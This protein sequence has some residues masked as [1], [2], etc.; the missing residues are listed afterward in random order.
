MPLIALCL[1]S[2][3]PAYQMPQLPFGNCVVL[4]MTKNVQQFP[5]VP[6]GAVPLPVLFFCCQ[7]IGWTQ[8]HLSSEKRPWPDG[9][10][11]CPDTFTK[12]KLCLLIIALSDQV[13]SSLPTWWIFIAQCFFSPPDL[14][15][16]SSTWVLLPREF[17]STY[18]IQKTK[19]MASGAI[20]SWQIDGETMET[21]TDL[22][23]FHGLQNH[24]GQW[25]QL[26]N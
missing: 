12:M 13:G 26:W 6:W 14:V 1:W 21:V 25:L 24:C 10:L 3:A 11:F 18:A 7:N 22:I 9:A 2:L 17:T 20:A 19:I 15:Y 5:N 16:N 23:Y 8:S 4:G